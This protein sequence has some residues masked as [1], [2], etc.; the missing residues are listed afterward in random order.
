MRVLLLSF[1]HLPSFHAG[2][3]VAVAHVPKIGNWVVL[4][5]ESELYV[6][7]ESCTN[8]LVGPTFFQVES[9]RKTADPEVSL[10]YIMWNFVIHERRPK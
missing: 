7:D 6:I 8:S 10:S 4:C 1:N 9:V 5:T 2:D 3:I